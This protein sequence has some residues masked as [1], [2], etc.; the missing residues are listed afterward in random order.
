MEPHKADDFRWFAL[1]DLPGDMVPYV[2]RAIEGWRAG[3]RYS[4]SGWTR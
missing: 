3:Q 1:D 2:R 4:E